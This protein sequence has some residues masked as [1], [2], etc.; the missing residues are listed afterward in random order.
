MPLMLN[1]MGAGVLSQLCCGFDSL[2]R[3]LRGGAVWSACEVHILEVGGS[4]PSPATKAQNEISRDYGK[5]G[6]MRDR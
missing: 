5:H 3:Y 4:N 1:R 2:Q 6:N